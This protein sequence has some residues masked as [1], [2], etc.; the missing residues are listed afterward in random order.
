MIKKYN[1]K[2]DTMKKVKYK[3]FITFL[4]ILGSQKY[5]QIKGL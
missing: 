2:N 1:S 3:R 5:I 4:F